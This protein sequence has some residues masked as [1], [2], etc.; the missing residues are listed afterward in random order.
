MAKVFLPK[1]KE[2]I[3][4]DDIYCAIEDAMWEI[5]EVLADKKLDGHDTYDQWLMAV[6]RDISRLLDTLDEGRGTMDRYQ[7]SYDGDDSELPVE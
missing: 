7:L 4:Q 2:I 5:R 1:Q 3:W 6:E